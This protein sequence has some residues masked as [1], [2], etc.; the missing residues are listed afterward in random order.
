MKTQRLLEEDMNLDIGF[1]LHNRYAYYADEI[2]PCEYYFWECYYDNLFQ[3]YIWEYLPEYNKDL[4]FITGK[5][6]KSR[7]VGEVINNLVLTEYKKEQERREEEWERIGKRLQKM[8]ERE[9][10]LS[11]LIYL[12]GIPL[13]EDPRIFMQLR[14]EQRGCC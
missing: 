2:S 8:G 9:R 3:F 14:R 11:E 7:K 4:M 5:E 6:F 12:A 13:A 1:A 10:E